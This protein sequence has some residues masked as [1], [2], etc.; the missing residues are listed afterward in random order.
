[1]TASWMRC[2]LII[3]YRHH[4]TLNRTVAES[5]AILRI[6]AASGYSCSAS[7]I[8]DKQKRSFPI[9]NRPFR[10]FLVAKS[11]ERLTRFQARSGKVEL[12]EA[13]R[14]PV[15]GELW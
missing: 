10:P 15:S 1:M 5:A 12:R 9:E 11:T 13:W 2:R 6:G 7:L 14:A 4:Y 8:D 3:P